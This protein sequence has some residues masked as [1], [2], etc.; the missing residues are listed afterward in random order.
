LQAL[1][2]RDAAAAEAAL[3]QARRERAELRARGAAPGAAALRRLEALLPHL[4]RAAKALRARAGGGAACP[5]YR[6]RPAQPPDCARAADPLLGGKVVA[7]RPD[8]RRD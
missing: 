8:A 6:L 3:A 5:D 4:E 7:L 2:E 1:R